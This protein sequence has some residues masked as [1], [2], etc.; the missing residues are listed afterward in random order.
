MTDGAALLE[1]IRRH[2]DEDMPRLMYADFIQEWEP[3]RAEFIRVQCEIAQLRGRRDRLGRK[4]G[5]RN[6]RRILPLTD[7]ED[8]I[9]THL[10]RDAFLN[11]ARQFGRIQ[12]RW[13]RGFIETFA[14]TGDAWIAHADGILA[15]HPVQEVTLTTWPEIDS[16]TTNP[17]SPNIQPIRRHTLR[18]K[19][20]SVGYV[21]T[22]EDERLSIDP[23]EPRVMKW[24]LRQ[25]W[26]T[27]KTWNLPPIVQWNNGT[28]VDPGWRPRDTGR[29]MPSL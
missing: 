3:E 11:I 10:N 15:Q 27:V 7:R 14:C 6:A 9:R 25:H 13:S 24:L 5:H 2:P 26:P 20:Y 23:W 12:L 22:E 18:G 29:L 4:I 28:F 17:S 8:E 1:A 21:T 19:S 16:T